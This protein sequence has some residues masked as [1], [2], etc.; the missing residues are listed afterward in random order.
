MT[1]ALLGKVAIVTGA[2]D[3]IGAATVRRFVAEGCRVL[4]SD[5]SGQAARLVEELGADAVAY[6][7]VDLA[8]AESAA[9]LVDA[10]VGRWGRLDVVF[11]NAGVMPSGTVETHTL[12]DLRLVLEV[13]AVSTFVLVQAAVAHMQPGGSIVL[14]SSVQGL[15]G[16]PDRFGYG[17]S[18]GALNAMTRSMAVDLAP[19]GIRVNAIC[20]GTI[21][22]PMLHNHLASIEDPGA[23]M[24]EVR[25]QHPL[26]RI[27]TPAEV[28][29]AVLFLASE[30]ASFVTGVALPVD[31]AMLVSG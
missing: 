25:R 26:G 24:A 20:P 4:A 18:K 1:G 3:G 11:A 2:G 8:D 6:H 19:R 9:G 28:A 22:T 7:R 29:N 5:R 23:V 17:A 10:A 31:G 13:N 27:G 15:Q 16:H 30:Q 21:D 14:T 12:A